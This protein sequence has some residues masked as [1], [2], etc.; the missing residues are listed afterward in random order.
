LGF[1]T[2]FFGAGLGDRV[3][4]YTGGGCGV[5]LPNSLDIDVQALSHGEVGI[6]SLEGSKIISLPSKF[7]NLR[8]PLNPTTHP[9]LFASIPA[10][11][12]LTQALRPRWHKGFDISGHTFLLTM[13]TLLL[14]RELY[15]SWRLL[16]SKQHRAGAN[17]GRGEGGVHLGVTVA[18][19]V[20]VGI[21]GWMLLMTSVW[22][23]NP[24][25]KISGLG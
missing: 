21:W 2:W 12:Q 5:V 25:E 23:H 20:L 11:P 6:T 9:S 24:P 18:G 13:S 14:V 16:V 3:I 7:C 19:T 10:S 1:T 17:V 8:L 22:F 15:P 4:E